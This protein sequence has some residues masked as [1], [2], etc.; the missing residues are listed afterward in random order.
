MTPPNSPIYP[1]LEMT[2]L[3][4][5]M[6]IAIGME[7]EAA[8]R[9]EQ[10]AELMELRG[11][12][13][14]AAAFRDLALLE[15]GHEA[16]LAGWARRDGGATPGP[17]AFAWPLPETFSLEDAD[18]AALTPYRALAIAVRNEERAFSFFTYLAGLAEADSPTRQRAEALAREE[19]KHVARLRRLRRRA[20]HQQASGRIPTVPPVAVLAD[21]HGLAWGLESGS[22]AVIEAAARSLDTDGERA[23]GALLR[24]AGSES[25]RR[26]AEL[27]RLAD[28]QLAPPGSQACEEARARGLLRPGALTPSDGLRLCEG[29]A[30]EVLEVYLTIADHAVDAA[31]TAVAEQLAEAAMGRL[32]LIRSQSGDAG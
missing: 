3:E 8:V 20:Y 32:G 23:A 31:I 21:L 29:D 16:G 26:A 24:H 14:L 15:R 1:I 17:A 18:D 2:S 25:A 11:E 10:L 28:G 9:Y 13:E 12:G 4:D 5:L 19:L 30:R 6:S 7:R 22:A 27:A